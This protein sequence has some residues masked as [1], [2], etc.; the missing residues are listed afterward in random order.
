MPAGGRASGRDCFRSRVS[1]L[2]RDLRPRRRCRSAETRKNLRGGKP[3]NRCK[4]NAFQSGT[5]SA[6]P[7]SARR[8]RYT[9]SAAGASGRV[10]Q[11]RSGGWW[12]R[13][14]RVSRPGSRMRSGRSRTMQPRVCFARRLAKVLHEFRSR[15]RF[16]NVAVAD[17]FRGELND[18]ARLDVSARVDVM[19]DPGGHRAERLAHRRRSRR[20]SIAIG[21]FA[22]I[23]TTNRRT[24]CT[25]SGVSAS[26]ADIFGPTG[27]IRVKPRVM[28][29]DVDQLRSHASVK[30]VVDVG[31]ANAR[32]DAGQQ[33]LAQ[34]VLEP[35]QRPLEHVAIPPPLVAHDLVAF[36]AKPAVS[37]CP[38][39]AAAS[40]PYP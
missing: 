6:A 16:E 21:S 10:P 38:A 27:A 4:T 23:S 37:H 35:A 33:P 39:A 1:R 22:R 31:L 29:A 34:A 17:I 13:A 14:R 5:S 7:E 12:C 20:R 28:D 32:G 26:S 36:D 11:A 9:D 18:R 30:S 40:P 25:C 3:Q 24:C 19:T 15:Q 2:R 8:R